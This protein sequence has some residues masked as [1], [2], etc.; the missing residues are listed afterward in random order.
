ML[1][2]WQY[3]QPVLT[4]LPRLFKTPQARIIVDVGDHATCER[5]RPFIDLF[6]PSHVLHTTL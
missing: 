3:M 2:G 1:W 4:R 6:M 5:K